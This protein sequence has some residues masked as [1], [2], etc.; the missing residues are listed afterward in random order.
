MLT[1]SFHVLFHEL[2]YHNLSR[3][4]AN[5]THSA[6][7]QVRCSVAWFL[8]VVS[9]HSRKIKFTEGMKSSYFAVA[10]A[11]LSVPDDS[12]G[13]PR[14]EFL[15]DESLGAPFDESLDD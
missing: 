7:G 14:D 9:Q 8:K 10:V 15:D 4:P 11:T 13:A 5:G 12:L 2:M 1:T 3:D 6:T